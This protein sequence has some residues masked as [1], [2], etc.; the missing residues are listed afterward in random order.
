MRRDRLHAVAVLPLAALLV[1]ACANASTG[2]A[3]EGPATVMVGEW[4]YR[5]QAVA[6][7][8]PT[9]AALGPCLGHSLSERIS[10]V[11]TTAG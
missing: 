4:T 5:S 7:D 6:P 1:N 11:F 2:P 3:P 8:P 9:S 10:T